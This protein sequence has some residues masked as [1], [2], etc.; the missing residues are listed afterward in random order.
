MLFRSE[1]VDLHLQAY[2]GAIPVEM[3]G[4]A[5]FRPIGDE[6]YF[7]SLGPYGFYWF[8][9]IRPGVAEARPYGIEDR[10]I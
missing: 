1:P 4:G 9:L 5:A 2:R 7:L 10:A 8:Q 6:P 3:F